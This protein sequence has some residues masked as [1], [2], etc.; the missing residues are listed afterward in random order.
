MYNGTDDVSKRLD[1][2]K[3]GGTWKE[4]DNLTEFVAEAAYDPNF[5]KDFDN[6]VTSDEFYEDMYKSN[7]KLWKP[8]EGSWAIKRAGC[9]VGKKATEQFIN[10]AN[11]VKNISSWLGSWI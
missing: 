4:M 3:Y 2:G 11:G 1:A 8:K 6:V 9:Y 7:D 5:K 10:V